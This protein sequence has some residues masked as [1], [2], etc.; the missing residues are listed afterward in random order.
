M[1]GSGAGRIFET[2]LVIRLTVCDRNVGP[3]VGTDVIG[4]RA[5]QAIVSALFDDMRR[6]ARDAGDDK[7][8]RE[9]RRWNT[10]QVVCA[11][12]VKIEVG[13]KFFLAAHDLLD[14][15]GH[16]VKSFVSTRFREFLR[17]CFDN[18]GARIEIL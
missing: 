2:V 9:H 6:P 8:W 5:D 17:P 13:E 3:R 15:L 14:A 1:I 7:E 10:T 11:G 16:G 12:A 4:I 18:V